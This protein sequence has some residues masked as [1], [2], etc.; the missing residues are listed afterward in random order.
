[1][2]HDLGKWEGFDGKWV[3]VVVAHGETRSHY[4]GKLRSDS[5]GRCPLIP[6]HPPAFEF[7]VEDIVEVHIA[8]LC[9]PDHELHAD[10][11]HLQPDHASLTEPP[12]W[13]K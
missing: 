10:I 8:D 2:S 12:N 3:H 1:M 5:L 6:M 11:R 4:Y 7:A 9:A 13:S